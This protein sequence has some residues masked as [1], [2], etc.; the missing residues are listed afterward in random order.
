MGQQFQNFIG[1]A[2]IGNRHN[3]SPC[4]T[5]PRS[6][7]TASPEWRKNDGVPVLARVAA[8]LRADKSRLS[9]AGHHHLTLAVVE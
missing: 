9:H 8:I 1:L 2:A 6:P 5:M 3:H 4:I 7:C